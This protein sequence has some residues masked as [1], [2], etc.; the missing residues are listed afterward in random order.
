MANSLFPA[1]PVSLLTSF[2]NAE[3]TYSFGTDITFA[4][5][6]VIEFVRFWGSL[7]PITTTPSGAVYLTSGGAPVSSQV[8]A[9][10]PAGFLTSAW[11]TVTLSSPVS[12]VTPGLTRRIVVGP[13]NRYA[14]GTGVFPRTANGMTGTAGYFVTGTSLAFPDSAP[15]TTWYSVDVGFTPSSGANAGR[16]IIVRGPRAGLRRARPGPLLLRTPLITAA[17]APLSWSLGVAPN[18][19][20]VGVDSTRASVLSQTRIR[21]NVFVTSGGEVYNPTHAAVAYAFLPG[22]SARPVDAD[23]KAGNWDITLIRSYVAETL[24][25][26]GTLFPL[27]KGHYY[28][29]LRIT[30]PVAGEVVIEPVGTLF[31][32]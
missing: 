6:G 10:Y 9:G 27:A 8:F 21:T 15:Q 12:L 16:T 20:E 3:A 29:W 23:W 19:W 26:P 11:N 1:N 28:R 7:N 2:D 25:G 14:A 4:D 24:V 13:I 18:K 32:D 22:A 30:D 17:R 5:P 31:M